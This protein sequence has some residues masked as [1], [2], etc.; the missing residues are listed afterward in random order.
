VVSFYRLHEGP[1]GP[2]GAV[3][4]NDALYFPCTPGEIAHFVIVVGDTSAEVVVTNTRVTMVSRNFYFKK[5]LRYST[6]KKIGLDQRRRR[7]QRFG[8]GREFEYRQY[9]LGRMP[10]DRSSSMQRF[11]TYPTFQLAT[12]RAALVHRFRF[13]HFVD[14]ATFVHGLRE[15]RQGKKYRFFNYRFLQKS[16]FL[17]FSELRF[18][19]F[20][21][22]V[23]LD[24]AH[25]WL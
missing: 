19:Y 18:C 21:P 6:S 7:R 3:D 12:G 17:I 24:R 10:Y 5:L 25:S 15:S 13:A 16:I 14:V 4:F 11:T 1:M 20:A 8:R 22:M 9:G 23:I 2:R